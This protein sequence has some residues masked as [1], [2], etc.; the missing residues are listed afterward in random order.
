VS[1]LL[2]DQGL[3][4]A[5]RSDLAGHDRCLVATLPGTC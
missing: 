5:C 3:S 2:S 4:V 1:A